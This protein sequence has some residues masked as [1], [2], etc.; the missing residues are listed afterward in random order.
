MPV[1]SV[2]EAARKYRKD[3]RFVAKLEETRQD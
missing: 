1:Y 3:K 2:I